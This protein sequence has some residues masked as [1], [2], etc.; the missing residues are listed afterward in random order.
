MNN[1]NQTME[2]LL[3][4]LIVATLVVWLLSIIYDCRQIKVT[5]KYRRKRLASLTVLVKSHENEPIKSCLDSIR[6]SRI[7]K[8]DVV[9]ID[10]DKSQKT[11][12]SVNRYIKKYPKFNLVYY[13]NN[14]DD[15]ITMSI[16]K[17]Y[18]F[19]K[20][21]DIVLVLKGTSIISDK[22]LSSNLRLFSDPALLAIKTPKICPQTDS[23]MTLFH[24]FYVQSKSIWLK[25]LSQLSLFEIKLTEGIFI[26]S[27]SFFDVTTSIKGKWSG[28]QYIQ[29]DFIKDDRSALKDLKTGDLVNTIS[30]VFATLLLVVIA[31]TVFALQ[32][33]SFYSASALERNLLLTVGFQMILVWTIVVT[34]SS[35]EENLVT[36][37]KL[38]FMSPLMYFLLYINL[39]V[40][41]LNSITAAESWQPKG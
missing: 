23:L 4:I 12:R 9:V 11:R 6:R 38:T 33:Y 36:K 1:L 13:P 26:R 14:P 2:I 19:S 27:S 24:H 5:K 31:L 20:R 40:F 22:Y 30:Q 35:V 8:C 15:G 21:G 3:A 41:I 29:D 10:L 25:A 32:T 7:K 18:Q 39:F 37:I 28:G 17:G 16:K 34:W